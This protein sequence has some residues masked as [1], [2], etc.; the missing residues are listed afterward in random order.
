MFY[1]VIYLKINVL[2]NISALAF[3]VENASQ[4]ESTAANSQ[5][6]KDNTFLLSL[7]DVGQIE[8]MISLPHIQSTGLC[9]SFFT[10]VQPWFKSQGT[11]SCQRLFSSTLHNSK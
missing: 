9:L 3:R 1:S 11:P 4:K 7:T 5:L 8:V 2:V 10:D 6:V